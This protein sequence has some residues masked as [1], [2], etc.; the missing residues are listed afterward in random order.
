MLGAGLRI[1]IILGSWI[2]I[3][4]RVKSWI[5]SV[6]KKKKNSGALEAQNAVAKGRGRS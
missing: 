2:Q 5:R 3:R 6:L 1:R 4:I